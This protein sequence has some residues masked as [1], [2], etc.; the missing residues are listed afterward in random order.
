MEEFLKLNCRENRLIITEIIIILHILTFHTDANVM[1]GFTERTYFGSEDNRFVQVTLQKK[2]IGK[3]SQ[4]VEVIISLKQTAGMYGDRIMS[5][6]I[7]FYV[8]LLT[9][10]HNGSLI[11]FD[12][13]SFVQTLN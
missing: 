7:Y 8:T 5:V 3:F 4:D 9:P 13:T 2:R 10:A 12:P 11:G 1:I 6:C